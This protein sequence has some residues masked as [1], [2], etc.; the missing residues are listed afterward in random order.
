MSEKKFFEPKQSINIKGKLVDLSSP[1]VMAILN[2]TPDSF[3][4][5]SRTKSVD[6]AL[7]KTEA[8]LKEGATFIDIGGYSSRPG[9]I[10]IPE[11]EES[12]RLIPVIESLVK[13]FPEVVISVDTFRA[14]VAEETIHAGAQIINDISAGDLDQHMFKTVARL[15]VPYIMM[16][17]QGT[18]QNMHQNPTY[19][20]VALDVI[21]HMAQKIAAL[22]AL[23]IHD[24]I[25]DPGFGF[26]KTIEHNYELL[27]NLD[28]FKIFKLPVLV[29]FS[30]KGMIYKALQTTAAEALNGTT[31][32][33]T[34]ALQKGAG[35]L[36]V[37]DVK[38]AMEC[39]ELI[40]RLNG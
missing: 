2:V 36:R 4:S 33:N 37:H 40:A 3:Y 1:K 17:M 25:I 15:Q 20:N 11:T 12:D 32:L 7:T 19:Q 35:I 24:I 29:G 22:K 5:S 27:Q 10:D 13:E 14:K 31:V 21:D 16:H 28:A 23:H 9:A 30:R 38:E 6:D 39:I 26:G 34:I 18:P 8:F